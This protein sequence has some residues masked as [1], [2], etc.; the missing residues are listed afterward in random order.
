MLCSPID[1]EDQPWRLDLHAN[2]AFNYS[3]QQND[4]FF[5]DRDAKAD[6]SLLDIG[7]DSYGFKRPTQWIKMRHLRQ[8]DHY[9]QPILSKQQQAWQ[10]MLSRCNGELPS[11]SYSTLKSIIRKGVPSN[12]RGRVWMHYSGASKKMEANPDVYSSLVKTAIKMGEYN[13]HAEVIQRDLHRTFP[14]NSN[15]ECAYFVDP[16]GATV[17]EPETNSKLQS[18]RRILLAFSIYSP[19]IGYCQSLNYLVGLFLLFVNTEEEAFWLL[20]T[21][22][23][24]YMP[25][26]MYDPTMEGVNIDQSVL[27]MMIY[28]KIPSIWDK[29]SNEGKCFWEN[30]QQEELPHMT[31]VTSHWFLTMFINILPIETVLRIWDCF[32]L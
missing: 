7:R 14:D 9:H 5:I 32:F 15:F 12:L 10:A 26:K 29:I 20:V 31:L 3:N 13:E 28:E 21:T 8:F 17:M 18:L 16:E 23:N 1:K 6:E 25:E 30:N 19:Q 2:S 22:V 24:D 4:Y 11:A 27:M